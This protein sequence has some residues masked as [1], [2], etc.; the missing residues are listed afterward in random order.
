MGIQ[1]T[2]ELIY[3]ELSYQI[4]GILFDV[5][6][7]IGYGHPEKYYYKA[8]GTSL[9]QNNLSFKKQLVIPLVFKNDKIGNYIIDFVVE[10]KIVLEVKQGN[11]FLKGNIKQVYGYLKSSGLKLGLLVNFTADRIKFKRILNLNS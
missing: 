7:T 4:V 5:Y 11:R 1:N 10:D 8:V 6:N 3:P 9:A 2:K